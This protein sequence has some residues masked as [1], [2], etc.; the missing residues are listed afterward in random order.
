MKANFP[1]LFSDQCCMLCLNTSIHTV[2]ITDEVEPR[3]NNQYNK[4]RINNLS[5]YMMMPC[6]PVYASLALFCD[7]KVPGGDDR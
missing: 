3:I 7:H 5:C 4:K 1:I 2:R 6:R